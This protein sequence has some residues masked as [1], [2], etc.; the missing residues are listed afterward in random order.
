MAK[1]TIP[2]P[3]RTM[4]EVFESLPEGTGVQLIANQIVMSPAPLPRHQIVSGEI[5]SE[6]QQIIKK[7]KLGILLFSPVDVFLDRKNAYQPDLVFISNDKM[8]IIKKKAIF[9]TPDLII[10]ITSVAFRNYLVL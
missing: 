7:R 9:G 1:E 5:Y 10:E 2:A 3:P 4:M 8:S 6:L